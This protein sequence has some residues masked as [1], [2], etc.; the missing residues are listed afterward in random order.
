MDWGRYSP[1][2][3]STKKNKAPLDGGIHNNLPEEILVEILA[4]LPVKSLLR[5]RCVSRSWL[6]LISSQHFIK[7]HLNSSRQDLN[8]SNYKIMLSIREFPTYDL[9]YCPLNF[10]LHEPWSTDASS[11]DYPKSSSVCVVGSCNGLI[12]LVI[13]EKDLFLWNPSTRQSRKL[14][15]ANFNMGR[16][17]SPNDHSFGFHESGDDYKVVN[18]LSVFEKKGQYKLMAMIYS[19]KSDS[20]KRVGDF[21]GC[22]LKDDF[23]GRVIEDDSGKFAS[24]KLHWCTAQSR[25]THEDA[26]EWDIIISLDIESEVFGVL[27]Q[28]NYMKKDKCELLLGVLGECICVLCENYENSTTDLW[29]LKEYGV[30]ESWTK[31]AVIPSTDPI[32]SLWHSMPMFILPNGGILFSTYGRYFVVYNPKDHSTKI[33]DI[34]NSR[35][36]EANIYVESLISPLLQTYIR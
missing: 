34:N 8:L 5:F 26:A 31:L 16:A 22:L 24:G 35:Y 25:F 17:G 11:I 2:S 13:N 23:K 4:K 30:K 36:S 20:W 9:K 29:V 19:L 6:E 12:C 1:D 18:I 3:S 14:P 27:E 33:F 7:A 28:P 15:P 21:K 10:L 32:D